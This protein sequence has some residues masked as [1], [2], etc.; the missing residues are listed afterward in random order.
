MQTAVAEIT[1]PVHF[2]GPHREVVY[3]DSAYHPSPYEHIAQKLARKL[4]MKLKTEVL[5]ATHDDFFRP[6]QLVVAA[7]RTRHCCTQVLHAAQKP[8][9][10]L[11]VAENPTRVRDHALVRDFGDWCR[12]VSPYDGVPH[13]ERLSRHL[14]QRCR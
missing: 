4:G 2:N 6:H 13:L 9:G 12:Y 1:P 3:L 5:E 11:F 10:V 14:L 8:A 7:V